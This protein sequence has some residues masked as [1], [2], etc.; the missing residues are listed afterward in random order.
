MGVSLCL[1]NVVLRD[2]NK[3]DILQRWRYRAALRLL[4]EVAQVDSQKAFS[5]L[6]ICLLEVD[7]F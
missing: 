4:S 7:M 5:P 2:L 6:P 3:M 1:F